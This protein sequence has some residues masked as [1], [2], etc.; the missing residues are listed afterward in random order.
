MTSISKICGEF[1]WACLLLAGVCR[2]QGPGIFEAA[3]SGDV[4]ALRR[5]GT[6]ANKIGETGESALSAACSKGH[7]EIAK[8]LLENGA[9]PLL[10]NPEGKTPLTSSAPDTKATAKTAR[11]ACCGNLSR[12]RLS[13]GTTTA[14]R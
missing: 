7:V 5:M 12:R 3:R 2:A 6:S 10:S 4:A 8:L 14:S 9:G 13:Y 1:F 11:A